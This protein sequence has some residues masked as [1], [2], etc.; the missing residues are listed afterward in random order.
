M[1][2]IA[3]P[4]DVDLVIAGGKLT[5]EDRKLLRAMIAKQKEKI[6]PVRS[7]A[8]KVRAKRARKAAP[9]KAKV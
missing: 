2:Y 1:G 8:V 6:K 3:E 4:K 9:L 5:V 7:R